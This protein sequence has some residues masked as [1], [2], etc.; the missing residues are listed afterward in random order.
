MALSKQVYSYDRT[1]SPLQYKI[2]RREVWHGYLLSHEERAHMDNMMGRALL[3]EAF[4]D[5]LIHHRD[6][7]LLAEYGFSA[8]TQRWLCSIEAGSLSEFAQAISQ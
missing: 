3:D 7:A 2:L 8:E 6:A 5:Q 4:C 1:T